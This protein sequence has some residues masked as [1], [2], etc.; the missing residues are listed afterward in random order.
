MTNELLAANGYKESQVKSP[1]TLG[2]TRAAS[3]GH[4]CT[5]WKNQ[6]SEI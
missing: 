4:T 2:F 5:L 1:G 3:G 6:N